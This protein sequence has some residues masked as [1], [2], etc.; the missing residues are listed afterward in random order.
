[1]RSFIPSIINTLMLQPKKMFLVDGFGAVLTA[2][3][4]AAVIARFEAVFGLHPNIA[5]RLSGVAVIFMIY[6]FSCYFLVSDNW[7]PF[8]KGI[9]IVNGAYCCFTMGLI[10]Y[11][12]QPLTALGVTYFLLEIMVVGG[13]AF[14]EWRIANMQTS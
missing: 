2:I 10:L 6:S 5:Y 1:M 14:F 3:L 7:R 12:Y 13:L 9:A 4:M 11:Y 8:L